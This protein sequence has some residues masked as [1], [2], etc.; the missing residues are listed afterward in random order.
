MN[1]TVTISLK[2]FDELREAGEKA[3]L[4]LK[5]VTQAA[6]ELEIFLSFI[7]TQE[8]LDNYI[9]EFNNQSTGSKIKIIDGRVKVSLNETD[10]N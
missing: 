6:K 7:I 10:S 3:N 1:G 8:N 5:K 9:E 4:L 2:D